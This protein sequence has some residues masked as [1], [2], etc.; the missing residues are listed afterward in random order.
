M[1]Q[2]LTVGLTYDPTMLDEA[3]PSIYDLTPPDGAETRERGPRISALY[4]DDMT[5]GSGVD[6]DT[7]VLLL[8][9][10]DRTAQATVSGTGLEYV[11][12][13]ELALGEHICR[14]TLS[15]G[16]KVAN[17]AVK[18]W[19]FTVVEALGDLVSIAIEPAT[20]VI[21]VG[22]SVEL[23]VVGNYEG[24]TQFRGLDAMLELVGDIGTIDSG[25]FTA[26]TAGTGVIRATY[27]DLTAESLVT[28]VVTS[29]VARIEVSP[30]Q[31][32]MRVGDVTAFEATAYDDGDVPVEG[33]VCGW[34]LDGPIGTLDAGGHLTATAEGQGTVRAVHKGLTASASVEVL[35]PETLLPSF[36]VS[37]IEVEGEDLVVVL[38]LDGDLPPG[39]EALVMIDSGNWRGAS[40]DASGGLRVGIADLVA[41]DHDLKVKLV[42]GN[43]ISDEQTGS[44]VTKEDVEDGGSEFPW[45]WVL[46]GIVVVAVLVALAGL[47]TRRSRGET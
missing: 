39:A 34:E 45:T 18:E 31:A 32:T 14:L 27:M 8:D 15:D 13:F 1:G 42:V 30:V 21:E 4:S 28:V 38:A 44:F 26:G 9:G 12:A 37:S 2:V 3:G 22:Q 35:P 24:G 46:I 40:V 23:L 29:T 7:V 25:T 16:A 10:I 47:G 5:G 19:T 43:E 36:S 17:E 11:P 33:F 20:I 6:V 41:G